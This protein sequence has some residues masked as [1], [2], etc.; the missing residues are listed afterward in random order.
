MALK[1]ELNQ[2]TLFYITADMKIKT[3]LY[4]SIFLSTLLYSAELWPQTA[5]LTKRLDAAHHRWQR[6]ILGVSWRDKLTNEEI[7]RRTAG[8]VNH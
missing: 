1:L 2:S 7:R 3:R 8:A 5:M 4:Q 6:S